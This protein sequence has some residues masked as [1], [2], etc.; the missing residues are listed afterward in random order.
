MKIYNYHRGCI[1][2]GGGTESI[3]RT[4][5]G[6]INKA[7]KEAEEYSKHSL[8]IN[9]IYLENDDFGFTEKDFEVLEVENG[10]QVLYT[11]FKVY[12]RELEE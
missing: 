4:Y 10:F 6:A 7:R 8:E 1:Y 11:I 9:K 12:E 5:E 2:E 3:H